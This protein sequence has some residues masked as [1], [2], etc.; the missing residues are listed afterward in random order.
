MRHRS[1]LIRCI[2]VSLF[3]AV[4][5]TTI[6]H[7]QVLTSSDLSRLRSIGSVALSPDA[8]SIAYTITMRDRPGRPY[9]QLWVMEVNSGRIVRLGGDKPAGN[10]L[11]SIDSKWIA[12]TGSDGDK[13][14]LMIAHPDGSEATFLVP[15]AGTN[16]P[17]PGTG[18]DFTWSPDAKQIAFISSTPGEGAEEA[19]GDPMV[20]TRYLYKPD[21]G[22]GSTRFNDNQRLHIFVVDVRSKQVRQLTQGNLSSLPTV[23]RIKMSSSTTICSPYNSPTTAFTASP[24]PN[25]TNTIPSGRPTASSSSTVAR[26]VASLTAKPP[27]KTLTSGS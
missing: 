8:H 12:F 10:P 9:G 22:E 4:L 16:S 19:K 27:W 23:S 7:A 24:P 17:L 1:T 15:L 13:Q 26:T 3:C 18:K 2:A 25:P 11:W 6:A 14:G 20:I 5:L 21:A